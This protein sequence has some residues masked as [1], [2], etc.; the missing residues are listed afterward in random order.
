[1]KQF[2]NPALLCGESGSFMVQKKQ[3]WL[4]VHELFRVCSFFF[5]ESMEVKQRGLSFRE[6]IIWVL[7][8]VRADLY[9]ERRKERK[10]KEK[11]EKVEYY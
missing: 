1:M 3:N 4:V 5:R 10:R 2:A 11:L 7:I 9:I 8:R 6:F